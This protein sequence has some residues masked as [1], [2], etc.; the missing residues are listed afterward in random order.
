MLHFREINVYPTG[1]IHNFNAMGSAVINKETT[2]NRSGLWLNLAVISGTWGGSFLFVKLITPEV[3][4]FA[5]AAERGFIA[6][7]A[8]LAWL[9]VRRAPARAAA[10]RSRQSG[11]SDFGHMI[12]LGTT[13]GWLANVLT[14]VAARHLDSATVAMS[15]AAVPVMV[16]VLAH[17]LFEDERF[18]LRQLVGIVTGFFG[19]LLIIG[20][21]A[22]FG[23][24]GSMIGIGAM[25]LTALSYAAGTVYRR[26][27]R[28]TD[29][30]VLACGQQTCGA[31]IA[32]AISLAI[33]TFAPARQ[34]A[35]VWLWLIVVGVLCSAV[36]TA[37]YLRLL[38]RAAAVPSALVAYLQPV[39]AAL[40]GWAVLGERSGAE[41]LIGAGLVI[42][43]IGV[44]TGRRT[45]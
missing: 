19:I 18:Q 28:A 37:M 16:A 30:A 1:V 13:N 41:A 34:S 20:P 31:V 44:S 33:E 6:A 45:G 21:L 36:P 22:V 14:A 25:L 10:T 2:L 4:P 9:A 42:V 32:A 38:T 29:S 15:Q 35:D 23:G 26:R 8:L 11:W 39:W 12:V 27:M 3:P 43:A 40:L 24:R 7:V 17:F 5:F